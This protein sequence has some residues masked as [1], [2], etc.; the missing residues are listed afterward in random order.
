MDLVKHSGEVVIPLSVAFAGGSDIQQ[1]YA[2]VVWKSAS[3]H[4]AL[5]SGEV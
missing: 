3:S 2:A 5:Q 1:T 4:P